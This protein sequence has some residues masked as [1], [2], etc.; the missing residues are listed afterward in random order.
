M[1]IHLIRHADAEPIGP[2]ADRDQDRPLTALGL[3][4]AAA[5]R[6]ALIKAEIHFDFVLS[7][8]Y[9][10]A[11]ETA[12]PLQ[13]CLSEASDSMLVLP[14]LSPREFS[15]SGLKQIIK[16]LNAESVALVGHMPTIAQLADELLG[17]VGLPLEFAKGAI[18]T[19]ELTNWTSHQLARLVCF[20]S[21]RW[22]VTSR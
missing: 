17:D 21:P 13:E 10:R 2:H 16:E 3:E 5:L 20:I 7:S 22:Y 19:I 14:E 4:Q 11:K 15:P 9:L 8:P 12:E 18:M 6:D 1:R